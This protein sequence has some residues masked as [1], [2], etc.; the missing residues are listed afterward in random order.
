MRRS[1]ISSYEICIANRA[2]QDEDVHVHA[3]ETDGKST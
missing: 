1:A 3:G 2:P